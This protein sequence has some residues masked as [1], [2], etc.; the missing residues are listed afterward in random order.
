MAGAVYPFFCS[1]SFFISLLLFLF[2][3]SFNSI[4][5]IHALLC[6]HAAELSAL[7]VV[8]AICV[9]QADFSGTAVELAD[10]RRLSPACLF[11][12]NDE[13]SHHFRNVVVEYS[14][15]L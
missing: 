5:N 4:C 6:G 7:E 12:V 8:G 3:H 1:V 11:T 2:N 10:I 15:Y 13:Y 14:S 9:V